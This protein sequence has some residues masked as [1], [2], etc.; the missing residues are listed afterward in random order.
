MIRGWKGR[1]EDRRGKERGWEGRSRIKEIQN[2]L[3]Q[4]S[5]S[6]TFQND[7]VNTSEAERLLF[8]P[9]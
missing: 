2:P 1:E 6:L 8:F 7:M 5:L 4:E 3:P 9:Q